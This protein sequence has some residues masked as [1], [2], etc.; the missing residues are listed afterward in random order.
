MC[1]LQC[2]HI[3]NIA[4]LL[5]SQSQSVL[6]ERRIKE[7]TQPFQS[8]SSEM[9]TRLLNR[10]FRILFYRSFYFHSPIYRHVLYVQILMHTV[11]T[12]L[13]SIQKASPLPLCTLAYKTRRLNFNTA[14]FTEIKVPRRHYF[15]HSC[16]SLFSCNTLCF[17]LTDDHHGKDSILSLLCKKDFGSFRESV[18]REHVYRKF[19]GEKSLLHYTVASGDVESVEHVLSLGAEVNCSTARGYTPLIMAVL[20]RSV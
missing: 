11:L 15:E 2:S 4:L 14:K 10:S 5:N 17:Y 12:E 18:K 8:C 20:H 13:H 19:S 1:Y 9:L 16:S 6:V 7:F 3:F